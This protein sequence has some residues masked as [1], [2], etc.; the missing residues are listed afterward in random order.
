V[1][2]DITIGQFFPGSSLIHRLDPRIK[3]ALT[4]AAIVFIFL[5][6]SAVSI[7]LMTLAAITVI[8]LTQIP[9]KLYFK[10]LKPILIIILITSLLN[11]FYI[12]T[13]NILWSWQFI[14]IT[15]QGLLRSALIALRIAIMILISCV[16][17]YTTSPTDLTDAIERLMK[18]LKYIKVPVHEI[19]MMMT[20]ALRFVPTLL[21]ETDKI[22]S[23]QKA[24]G[25][26][27]ESGSLTQRIRAMIP[28]LIPLFVSAFRRAYELAMAMECRCYHGGEGRTRMKQLHLSGRDYVS[29]VFSAILFCGVILCNQI[30]PS[31]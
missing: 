4:F 28:I 29:L 2:K 20:I 6:N 17:T 22:T 24:R 30:P 7:G 23:A 15:D 1:I 13:G 14:T 3:I 10:G 19:A 8:I 27:L 21:E 11:I 31:L 25:A 18:P 12:R 9:A 16:L 26:D 5:A